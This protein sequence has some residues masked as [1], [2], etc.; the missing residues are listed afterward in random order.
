MHVGLR[1]L[2]SS[3]EELAQW[4]ALSEITYLPLSPA[5][6]SISSKKTMEGATALAFLNTC[7]QHEGDARAPEKQSGPRQSRTEQIF[8]SRLIKTGAAHKH[9]QEVQHSL[10]S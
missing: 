9:T 3:P 10:M 2:F 4:R 1:S 6:A 8:N 7:E 5:R